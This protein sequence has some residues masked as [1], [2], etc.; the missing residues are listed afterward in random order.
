MGNTCTETIQ[1]LAMDWEQKLRPEVNPRERRKL[2]ELLKTERF[3]V[4]AVRFASR[5]S[6]CVEGRKEVEP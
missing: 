5:W 2:E 3:K 4:W 6:E 1:K